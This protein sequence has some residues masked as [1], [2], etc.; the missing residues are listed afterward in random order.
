MFFSFSFFQMYQQNLICQYFNKKNYLLCCNPDSLY[1]KTLT[2]YAGFKPVILL[3]KFA[4]KSLVT[5]I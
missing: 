1:N 3:L 4:A 2:T 5:L